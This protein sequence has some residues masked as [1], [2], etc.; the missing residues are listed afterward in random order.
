[1]IAPVY[2]PTNR[3]PFAPHPHQYLLF[4]NFFMLSI[5]IDVRQY[6]IMVLIC[7]SLIISNVD[8]L[9]IRLMTTCVSFLENV[10]SGLL[11]IFQS[12]CF[13]ILSYMSCL[14]FFMFTSYQ[15]YH[16]DF[17]GGSGGKEYACNVA[18]LG[19]IPGLGRSPR[20]GNSYPL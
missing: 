4:V 1:M 17:P 8:H 2:I 11:P 5:L 19:S 10:Y 6:L 20:E 13:L 15:S 12:G 9:F 16:L 14:Y 3:V 18:D 7:I